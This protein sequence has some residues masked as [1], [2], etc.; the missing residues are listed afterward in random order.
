MGLPAGKSPDE[1]MERNAPQH[2]QHT[3]KPLQCQ[4]KNSEY[5]GFCVFHTSFLSDLWNIA[6]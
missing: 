1:K 5:P 4:R 3:T 2:I 6:S